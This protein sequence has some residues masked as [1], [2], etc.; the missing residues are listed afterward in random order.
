METRSKSQD[1]E[2]ESRVQLWFMWS[3]RSDS[4]WRYQLPA[5]YSPMLPLESRE[6]RWRLERFKWQPIYIWSGWL[7]LNLGL[8][9]NV[10]RAAFETSLLLEVSCLHW[11]S[12]LHHSATVLHLNLMNQFL[13]IRIQDCQENSF[14]K[15]TL[16]LSIISTDSWLLTL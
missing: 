12:E 5:T 3:S 14:G 9:P 1:F 16:L 7:L 2:V 8:I 13:E 4:E 6:R 10:L 15:Q 11:F